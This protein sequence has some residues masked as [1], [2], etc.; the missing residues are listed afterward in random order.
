MRRKHRDFCFPFE[1]IEINKVWKQQYLNEHGQIANYLNHPTWLSGMVLLLDPTKFP[2]IELHH[3]S[4]ATFLREPNYLISPHQMEICP[5]TSANMS[6]VQYRTH[7]QFKNTTSLLLT[8]FLSRLHKDDK[9]NTTI[10]VEGIEKDFNSIPQLES[11]NI[12]GE[13]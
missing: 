5:L 2:H 8:S 4:L 12:Y 10:K 1:L 13:S 6:Q 7:I 9:I 3:V 11:G